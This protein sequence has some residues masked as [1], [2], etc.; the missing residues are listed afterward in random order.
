MEGSA[1]DRPDPVHSALGTAP[2]ALF[3]CQ[4][5]DTSVRHRGDTSRS[6]REGPNRDAELEIACAKA[7]LRIVR[8][9]DLLIPSEA[10][11]GPSKIPFEL[12][13]THYERAAA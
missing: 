6:R 1:A 7:T 8:H 9:G 11:T 5:L 13:V 2:G 3:H 10:I 4:R 12:G